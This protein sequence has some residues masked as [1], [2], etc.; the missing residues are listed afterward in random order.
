MNS[1]PGKEAIDLVARI[2]ADLARLE[3]VMKD[4]NAFKR[5]RDCHEMKGVEYFS[6]KGETNRRS[7]VCIECHASQM[8][9]RR[10]GGRIDV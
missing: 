3:V 7:S 2:H 1:D 4:L 5:C 9:V 8:R 6:F 10:S